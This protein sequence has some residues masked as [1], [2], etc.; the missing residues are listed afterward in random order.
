MT[1]QRQTPPCPTTR[2]YG[3][4]QSGAERKQARHRG[5]PTYPTSGGPPRN[6]TPAT[7]MRKQG[8]LRKDSSPTRGTRTSAT[9]SP[10]EPHQ[11]PPMHS[12]HGQHELETQAPR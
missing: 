7:M 6:H 12:T 8:S 3:P 10:E 1:R 2:G 9:Y 11:T 5:T 4:S